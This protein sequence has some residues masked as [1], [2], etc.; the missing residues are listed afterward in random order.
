MSDNRQNL[1]TTNTEIIRLE[2]SQIDQAICVA[3]QAFDADPW[4]RYFCPPDDQARQK[5]LRWMSQ[6]LLRYHQPYPYIYTTPGKPKGVAIWLPPGEYPFKTWR[7]L[8]VGGYGFPWQLRLNRVYPALSWFIQAEAYHQQ[9]ISQPHWYLSLLGVAPEAQGQGI[10]SLLLQPVL[11]AAD[12][13]GQSCYLETSTEAAVRFYQRHG[14]A[15]LRTGEVAVN[16]PRF[17]TMGRE[18]G[19]TC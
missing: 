2:R 4:I 14:F 18:P 12:R 3:A 15:I 1:I 7:L 8:Q 13:N 6:M 10:G 17:W 16:G 19:R 5:S 9:D 11:E